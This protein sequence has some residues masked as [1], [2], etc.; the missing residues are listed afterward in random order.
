MNKVYNFSI[1][2]DVLQAVVDYLAS[3]PY[4]EVGGVMPK[5]VSLPMTTESQTEYDKDNG[6]SAESEQASAE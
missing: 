6:K 2:S 3:R 1:P 5:L 4:K